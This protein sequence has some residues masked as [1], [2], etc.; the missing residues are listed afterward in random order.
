MSIPTE[1][2]NWANSAAAADVATPPA[3]TQAAGW[4]AG[5][6]PPHEWVNWFWQLVSQWLTYIAAGGHPGT[7]TW[8]DEAYAAVGDGELIWVWHPNAGQGGSQYDAINLGAAAVDM[9]VDGVHVYYLTST[10]GYRRDRRGG[11]STV[12]YTPSDTGTLRSIASDGQLVVLAYG[13]VVEAFSIDGTS[14][15]TYDHGAAVNDVAIY[16]PGG[17]SQP[18]V[19]LCGAADGTGHSAKSL[20]GDDGTLVW[21]YNHGGTLQAIAAGANRCFIAGA[22]SSHGSGATLRAL[23]AFNGADAANEGGTLA[24]TLAMAWDVVQATAQ[25]TPHTL[26]TDGLRLVCGYPSTA[27]FEID[28]RGVGDGLVGV[29]RTLAQSVRGVAIDQGLILA[30][31]ETG[32]GDGYVA[33]LEFG[34]LATLWRTVTHTG[35]VPTAVASDGQGVFYSTGTTTSLHWCSRG[36]NKPEL[37]LRVDYDEAT[38]GIDGLPMTGAI[39]PAGNL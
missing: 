17:A 19:F 14:L 33:A 9:D 36:P 20:E 30:A 32:A 16:K 21:E 4:P 6:K 38:Y 5:L 25:A 23:R 12:T 11:G 34:T 29:E 7:A 3:A 18:Q 26:A 27:T 31:I 35:S 15:W 2:P 10:A 39:V 8:I 24:D 28:V 1:V 22:A 37:F 13:D